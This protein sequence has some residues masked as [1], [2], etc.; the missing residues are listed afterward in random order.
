MGTGGNPI[1]TQI[2]IAS[3]KI[4][5]RKKLLF[6]IIWKVITSRNVGPYLRA[7]QDIFTLTAIKPQLSL[8]R[9]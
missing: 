2:L 4:G 8:E 5:S 3:G 9:A 7:Q 1:V 6:V